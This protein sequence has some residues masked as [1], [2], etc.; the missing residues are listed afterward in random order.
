MYE[1]PLN[2]VVEPRRTPASARVFPVNV[3]ERELQSFIDAVTDFF[4]PEKT[5]F[6]TEIWLDELASMER[7]PEP[8]SPDW[9]LVTL[10]ASARLATCFID[11]P[12][13]CAPF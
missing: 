7:M 1:L 11:L 3:A 5:K 6:L 8:T 13:H 2:E 9:H 4:G 12:H 10:A